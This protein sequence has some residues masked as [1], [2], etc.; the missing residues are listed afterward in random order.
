MKISENGIFLI[1]SFE[2][3]RL[4]A[5]LCPA[6]VWTIGYGHTA[7]V[8]QGQ[9]ITQA[10]AEEY[11]KADLRKYENYVSSTGLTLNQS[12]FD[13]LVSF[14]YNCGNGNLKKL[15]K[16]RSLEQIAEAM[17][18]YNK[19][20]GKVLQGLVERR[21]AEYSLFTYGME[22]EEKMGIKTYSKAAHGNMDISKNFKIREFACKDGSDAIKIDLLLVNHLQAAREYFGVP[23]VI[24]SAYRSAAHNK[25]V[26]GASNSYHVNGQA[27]DHHAK[28]KVDLFDLAKFYESR[29]CLGIIV[30]PNSGF[31]HIDTRTTKYYAVDYGN[32]IVAK[33]SFG[34]E[35]A[36]KQY[37]KCTGNGVRLRK[38]A[39]FAGKIL[40]K[41]YKGDEFE[42]LGTSGSWTKIKHNG[43]IGYVSS[44]Y[45]K[46][47]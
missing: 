6:G 25:K 36:E 41:L 19:S 22:K 9:V 39:G 18:L 15:I 12:Q 47:K 2:G 28:G 11:L 46:C 40:K 5:Y 4:N 42:I 34:V 33:T 27:A 8:K 20:N 31:V 37:G 35:R 1:K 17:L 3:C 13:A 26:G 44:Q 30:Y 21:Q 29:G 24:T 7:G 14:A 10:Q 32:S 23:V 43:T 16:N 38:S 45:V